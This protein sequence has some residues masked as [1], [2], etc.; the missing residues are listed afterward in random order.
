MY[1]I[2]AQVEWK[3]PSHHGPMFVKDRIKKRPDDEFHFDEARP[4]TKQFHNEN[5][6]GEWVKKVLVEPV[7]DWSWFK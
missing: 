6:P 5:R 2:G 4:W 1:L 7:K 3:V